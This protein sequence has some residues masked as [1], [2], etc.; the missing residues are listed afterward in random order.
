MREFKI[1]E[2]SGKRYKNPA[3]MEKSLANDK[4][5]YTASKCLINT[6]A[7]SRPKKMNEQEARAALASYEKT[8]GKYGRRYRL[9]SREVPDWE[10]V[11]V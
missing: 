3:T 10:V 9:L 8:Y 1:Q 4:N 5:W 2:Y 11:D 7:F 6:G